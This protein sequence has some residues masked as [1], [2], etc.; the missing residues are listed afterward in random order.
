MNNI[1]LLIIV[2]ILSGSASAVPI[3]IKYFR[4]WFLEE[5]LEY[6]YNRLDS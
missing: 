4:E 6:S 2:T 1:L 3:Y 5:E